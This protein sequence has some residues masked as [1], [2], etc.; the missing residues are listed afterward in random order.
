M[1]SEG[2]ENAEDSFD[3]NIDQNEVFEENNEQQVEMDSLSEA[4]AENV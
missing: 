3:E 1:A 4:E 2:S